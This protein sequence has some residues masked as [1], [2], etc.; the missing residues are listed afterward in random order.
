MEFLLRR[1]WN[2]K[3]KSRLENVRVK[4]IMSINKLRHTKEK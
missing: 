2:I 3:L 4:D 1:C